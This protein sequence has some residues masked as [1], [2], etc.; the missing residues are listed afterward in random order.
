MARPRVIDDRALLDRSMQLFWKNGYAS[1]GI[2][3]LEG[4]LGLKASAI[5]NRFGS[6][7]GLFQAT[8]EYYID[9]VI[10]WRIEHYLQAEDPMRGLRKFFDTTY[11]Y[12]S[13]DKP[14][15]SCLLVNTSL[16]IGAENA[17]VHAILHRGV[18][19]LR[20][21]F[22]DNLR[23]CQSGGH[24]RADADIP[25]LSRHLLICLHGLTVASTLDSDQA[26]LA[27]QVDWIMSALPLAES[28]TP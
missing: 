23:R 22:G 19:R 17:A 2:R 6:K 28:Q 11:N 5:Y 13:I 24:I 7:D 4:T 26:S 14:A 8:I 25:T 21:A 3:D 20:A 15:L 27:R 9:T 10:G 18:D 1:T 12:I 16:E